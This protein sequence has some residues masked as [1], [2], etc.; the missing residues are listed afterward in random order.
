[1]GI[2]SRTF[3][4]L[5][6]LGLFGLHGPARSEVIFVRANA[7]EGAGDGSSWGDAYIDLQDALAEVASG[8]AV[9]VAAGVYAP[10]HERGTSFE[11]V[12]GVALFGGFGGD[13]IPGAFDLDDRDLARNETVLS[14]DLGAERAYHVVVAEGVGPGSIVD[15]F[16]ISGGNAAGLTASLDDV[17]G[18][19]LIVDASPTIRRCNFVDHQAGT[20]GGAVHIARGSPSF[21][22][23]RFLNSAT[24]VTQVGRNFGGA[25]YV[26]GA[27]FAA[28]LPMFVNCLFRGNRAGVGLGGEGGAIYVGEFARP[29]V[30][31]CTIVE[32]LADGA[33]GGV[34]G[35]AELVNSVLWGNVGGV[36][37]GN[38]AQVGQVLSVSYSLLP[39]KHAGAG[40]VAGDPALVSRES[41]S[42]F[43]HPRD[44]IPSPGSM[45]IDAGGRSE[46]AE[47]EALDLGGGARLT[48]D[49]TTADTGEPSAFGPVL[50]IGAFEHR[51]RCAE[52][53]DCDDGRIC[54]GVEVC[55]AGVCAPG[56][57]IDC[58]DGVACTADACEEETARCVH[59]PIPA[60]CDD[61]LFCNGVERCDGRAGCV[62]GMP[63]ACDD[64]IACTIDTCDEAS[65]SCLH[66]TDDDLCDDGVVCNGVERCDEA[67]GCAAGEGIDCDDGVPCTADSC[68][69]AD[70]T[71][72]HAPDDASCDDGLYCNGA[73]RC[74]G[75][76]GCLMGTPPCDGASCDEAADM[77]DVPAQCTS[78]EDCDDGNECTIPSCSEGVCTQAFGDAAC[79]DGD[80]CTS[81]DRCEQGVC[82]GDV[83]PGCDGSSG[84][85]GGGG[86][87]SGPAGGES[88][89]DGDGV[90]DADDQC[91]DTAAGAAVDS[92]G[93]S[94]EQRD[95][96]GD[97]VDD[98]EDACASTPAG[99]I[100]DD[101]GCAVVED[102]PPEDAPDDVDDGTGSDPGTGQGSPDAGETVDSDGDGV[103]DVL[104][105]CPGTA[106]GVRADD[107][108]CP[109]EPPDGGG[110]DGDMP[111]G[112]GLGASPCG[113]C[114]P[115]QSVALWPA[116]TLMT[117]VRL[118]RRRRP[119]EALV[120]LGRTARLS[121]DRREGPG[122]SGRGSTSIAERRTH[123]DDQ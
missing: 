99:S 58:D 69:D 105:A 118:A 48:D 119:R 12:D 101:A 109:V 77:C 10:G 84:G 3:A 92:S 89:L 40:N 30:A 13:E 1:M 43:E 117:I 121:A 75:V 53:A 5:V 88:D 82:T 34:F 28:S 113:S 57:G 114:G 26:E 94:C 18:G 76:A 21:V 123:A 46:R 2:G 14:G 87:G 8:D 96:D 86:G 25:V 39:E 50:D 93:C 59:V 115:V 83:I 64:R 31:N 36:A 97:G 51:A 104:D 79:D 107:L 54:N 81:D 15:G 66:E 72:R 91:A 56:V 35:S 9:W 70:G 116:L 33:V 112:Q 37:V 6:A 108:G 120:R 17:G 45:V 55:M 111:I 38:A 24:T 23:C 67:I 47:A 122:G 11:L 85:D 29:H 65:R 20:K 27:T 95:S 60:T 32:N 4:A 68:D 110:L 22:S 42:G 61:G 44:L 90:E 80:A 41:W 63:P 100:V 16:T 78:D 62:A 74:D 73:E 102:H 52:D 71:C 19:L 49:P 7:G 103:V 106:V 98:C